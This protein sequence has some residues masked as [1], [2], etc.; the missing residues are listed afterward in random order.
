MP[1]FHIIA[2]DTARS[3]IRAAIA[4]GSVAAAIDLLTQTGAEEAVVLQEKYME[5]GQQRAL[6]LISP[7]EW[8]HI[9][10]Q[11]CR[12]M[13]KIDWMKQASAPVPIP[14][15]VK[16][17][18]LLLL[19]QRHTEQALALCT[20]L[21]DDFL[22]LQMYLNLA[23]NPSASSLM[24]SEYWEVTKSKVN[25]ALQELLEEL[26]EARALKTGLFNKMRRW[27]H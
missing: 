19:E 1:L 14:S 18:I 23:R 16:P 12:N 3:Q 8:G 17:Q 7:E 9:Q 10:T 13:L 15:E 2:A 11:L 21:G 24:E 20:D 5:A 27:F 25:Y 4:Q 26:P 22:L 6:G